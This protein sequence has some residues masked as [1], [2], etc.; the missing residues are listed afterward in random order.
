MPKNIVLCCDG[1][2]NEYGERHT[3]VLKLYSVLEKGDRQFTYYDPGVGTL[4][5]P[6]MW[7]RIGKDLSRLAG[8]AFGAGIIGDIEEA[9][10]FL[11][12]H[13]EEND[14]IFIFGFS[15][16]QISNHLRTMKKGNPDTPG[17]VFAACPNSVL[18]FLGQHHQG[19]AP[20]VVYEFDFDR[21]GNKSYQPSFVID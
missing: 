9:Y 5:A 21:K 16:E 11:M 1:T 7:S 10:S 12:N 14:R 15:P 3:N 19:I 13:Y 17:H 18:F 4:S 20:C 8:L 2:G 6:T